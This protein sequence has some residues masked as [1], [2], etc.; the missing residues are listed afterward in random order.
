MNTAQ[1]LADKI[2]G[3]TVFLLERRGKCF[4]GM[5]AAKLFRYVA[6]NLINGNLFVERDETGRVQMVVFAWRDDAG[7][8]LRRDAD[9]EPQFTWQ[10]PNHEGNS[11]LIGQVIGKRRWM[12][13]LLNMVMAHWPASP[14]LRLFTYRRRHDAPRL[15]EITWPTIT[16]FTHGFA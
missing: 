16:R 3:I 9:N 6:F 1:Q 12:P 14:R 10:M 5:D 13:Q 7:E 8:I 4:A 2:K 15:T 11:I